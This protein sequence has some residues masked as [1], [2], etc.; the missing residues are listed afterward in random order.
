MFYHKLNCHSVPISPFIVVVKVSIKVGLYN[1]SSWAGD[2]TRRVPCVTTFPRKAD[3][4]NNH[5]CC[6]VLSSPS[7]PPLSPPYIP[8]S[9]SPDLQSYT[10][11]DADSG[12]IPPS[13]REPLQAASPLLCDLQLELA[14][15]LGTVAS[16]TFIR[17]LILLLQCGLQ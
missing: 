10:Q 4:I 7:S 16:S 8:F 12:R 9:Y 6:C 3:D 11:T 14:A 17:F 1:G 13:D 2:G 5:Y 15:G